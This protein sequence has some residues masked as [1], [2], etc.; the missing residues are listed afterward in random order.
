MK[1]RQ[2]SDGGRRDGVGH[3]LPDYGCGRGLIT[4]SARRR[5]SLS[6]RNRIAGMAAEMPDAIGAVS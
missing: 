1:E 2:K 5:I 4:L 3:G 6:R